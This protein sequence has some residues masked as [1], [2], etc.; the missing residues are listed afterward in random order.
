MHM[1]LMFAFLSYFNYK[2][3]CLRIS[4][5]FVIPLQYY[6]MKFSCCTTV[7]RSQNR[8]ILSKRDNGLAIYVCMQEY[9]NEIKWYLCNP[10][11]INKFNIKDVSHVTAC[12]SYT[13]MY[14]CNSLH[15]LIYK[16]ASIGKTLP[17]I[18]CKDRMLLPEK[19][20]K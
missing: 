5:V 1:L 20:F 18:D 13:Y 17:V 19:E 4:V 3:S 8:K 15:T 14:T 10:G 7:E 16:T 6:S 12:S 11:L 2:Y 9:I